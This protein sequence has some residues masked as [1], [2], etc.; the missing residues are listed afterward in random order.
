MIAGKLGV[1]EGR[2]QD[3]VGIEGKGSEMKEG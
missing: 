3:E 2:H 1:A